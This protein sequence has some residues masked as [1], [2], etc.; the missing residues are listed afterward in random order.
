MRC[1]VEVRD[2]LGMAGIEHSSFKCP[3][4]H[5]I[6]NVRYDLRDVSKIWCGGVNCAFFFTPLGNILT[7]QMA[8]TLPDS[9]RL[10]DVFAPKE[11]C[12]KSPTNK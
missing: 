8:A 12:K 5:K 3:R 7:D 9:Y 2:T 6:I 10:S 4:C 1:E 11:L